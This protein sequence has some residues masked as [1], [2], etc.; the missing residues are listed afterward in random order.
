[1]LAVAR[2]GEDRLALGVLADKGDAIGRE[3]LVERHI[4]GV[5]L[6]DGERRNVGIDRLVEEQ[7]QAVAGG[8]P[9]P[10]KP[11]CELVGAR[12]ELGERELRLGAV[13][14][15]MCRVAGGGVGIDPLLEQMFE[16]LTRKGADVIGIA[17]AEKDVL[18]GQA[19]L[20]RPRLNHGHFA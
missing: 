4:G 1:V 5:E 11:A 6:Q 7:R 13:D 9:L 2:N 15:K 20:G 3:A 10:L 14:R 17:F 12:V 19:R 8:D 16:T 18:K